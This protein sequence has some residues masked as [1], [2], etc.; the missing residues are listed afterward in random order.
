MTS[1]AQLSSILTGAA[2]NTAGETMLAARIVPERARS[3]LRFSM[4][5]SPSRVLA[6]QIRSWRQRKTA[7]GSPRLN[8]V[9]HGAEAWKRLRPVVAGRAGDNAQ[10]VAAVAEAQPLHHRDRRV[11]LAADRLDP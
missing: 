11:R 1:S 3:S 2:E 9:A 4:T 6:K 7:P 8:S 5:G 10:C